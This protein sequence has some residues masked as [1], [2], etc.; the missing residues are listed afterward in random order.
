MSVMEAIISQ[1]IV[2]TDMK[3][4]VLHVSS[5]KYSNILIIAIIMQMPS[6]LLRTIEF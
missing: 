4:P 5:I 6:F 3:L 2:I 1:P